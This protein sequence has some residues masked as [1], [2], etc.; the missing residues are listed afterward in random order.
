[1]QIENG[2]RTYL[3]EIGRNKVLTREE[4]VDLFKR[5]EQGDENARDIIVKCNLKFVI[6]LA[7]R[8]RNRGL[9]L[10]DLIQEGNIGLLEAIGKFKYALGFRFSTYAAFWIRQAIQVAVRQRGSLIRLPV[11]KTRLL[12]FMNEVIQEYMSVKGCPPTEEELAERLEISVEK[13]QELVQIGEAV[14]SLDTPADEDGVA[15][16]ELI[17]DSASPS[18]EAPI[19]EQEM[20]IK[21]GDALDHLSERES[22]IIRQRVGFGS[23][24]NRSLRKVSSR[25]GL[26]Q[27]GVRRIEQRAL[28]KLRRPHVRQIITGLI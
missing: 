9:P 14:L 4:E 1:M 2:L 24:V 7:Q 15:L 25:M 28:N 16:M 17:P 21:V 20:K 6:R 23:G 26:S 5:F 19:Q 3:N 11:R 10:D 8:F 22:K 18:V 27:E 12:G 13:T